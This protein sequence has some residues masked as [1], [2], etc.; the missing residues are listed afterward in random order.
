MFLARAPLGWVHEIK[1]DGYLLH[2]APDG[3]AA[4][5]FTRNGHGCVALSAGG[6]YHQR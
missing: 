5:L 3:L 1:H 4:R 6:R 2:R